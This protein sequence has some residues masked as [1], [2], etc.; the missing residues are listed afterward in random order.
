MKNKAIDKAQ[1]NKKNYYLECYSF[2]V[3]YLRYF[4]G[5]FTSEDLIAAYERKKHPQPKD[6]RVW[7][8]VIRE[9]RKIGRLKHAGYS[10]YRKPCGH[11]KPVN[12]WR[13]NG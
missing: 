13:V 12:V 6:L 10:E 2:A 8:A 1:D 5:D 9:L 4:N 11:G 7:G 3:R